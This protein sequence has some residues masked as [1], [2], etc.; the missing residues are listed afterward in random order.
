MQSPSRLALA[1]AEHVGSLL[2][3]PALLAARAAYEAGQLSR[4]QLTAAEDR[5]ILRVLDQQRQAGLEILTDGEYRR[6]SWLT[7]IQEAVEGFASEHVQEQWSGRDAPTT[8]RYSVRMVGGKLRQTAPL[9]LHEAR[10]LEQHAPGQYKLCI[11]S[12]AMY[13]F[14]SYQPGLTDQY[15]PQRRDL[16]ADVQ[17]IL[18]GEIDA[19][20][21]AGVPYVQIDSPSYGLFVDDAARE[22]LTSWGFTAQEALDMMI[23]ADNACLRAARRHGATTAVHVCRGNNRGRW[24]AQGGYDAI[25]EQLFSALEADRFLLEYDTE[26][27]GTF[28]P[29]RFVPRG[30]LAVLG[31]VSTKEPRVES[32]DELLQS[33]DRAAEHLPA[34]QLALTTACGFSTVS[35]GHPLSLDDQQRKLELLVAVARRAWGSN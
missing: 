14:V 2:R 8:Q 20:A 5:A 30:K 34:D 28:A 18:V 32:P 21:A 11:P 4:E 6:F 31:L 10:F 27:A 15:Y 3:P 9:N 17:A 23:A 12:P 7:S 26:R 13:M 22:R 16:V 35:E 24:L 29:L 1:R 19:L 33:I 25:A